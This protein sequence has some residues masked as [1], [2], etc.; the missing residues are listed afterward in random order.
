MSL[1][2]LMPLSVQEILARQALGDGGTIR[3]LSMRGPGKPV[4]RTVR[5]KPWWMLIGN[6][7]EGATCKTCKF[8]RRVVHAKTYLKCGK[9]TIT[10]GP[11][12]DIHAKDPACRLYEGRGENA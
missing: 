2:D 8:L 7:P 12:T 11:G 1:F 3:K 4:V 9:Q 5:H 6:G 10:S